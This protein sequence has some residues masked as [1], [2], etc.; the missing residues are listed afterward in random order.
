MMST[1]INNNDSGDKN[2]IKDHANKNQ[3][4]EE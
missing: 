4:Q 3:Q 1:T 2:N